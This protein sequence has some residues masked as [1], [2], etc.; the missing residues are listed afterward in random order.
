M[1]RGV[2]NDVDNFKEVL[3]KGVILIGGEVV[4]NNSIDAEDD[5]PVAVAIIVNVTGYGPHI[6]AIS[7]VQGH[8]DEALNVAHEILEEWE[9]DHNPDYY[10]EL[11]KEY[12][13]RA[14]E[15]FTETFDGI[16]WELPVEEFLSAIEGTAAE[17]FIDV[18]EN[19]DETLEENGS[20]DIRP[21][22]PGK[23][24]TLLDSYTY[25]LTLDGSDREITFDDGGGYF[26][27]EIDDKDP[28]HIAEIATQAGDALNSA[29]QDFLSTS[30]AVIFFQR[31]DGIVESFWFDNLEEAEEEWTKIE[32]EFPSEGDE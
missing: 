19:E 11:E 23:F 28:K 5:T 30:A 26:F 1:P 15:V 18:V 13:D 3:A 20:G 8:I 32:E 16:M 25:E 29:E 6:G 22:G 4:D 31:T 9:K 27:L 21:Y 12:G 17:K 7:A 14:D 24:S 10:A 2:S